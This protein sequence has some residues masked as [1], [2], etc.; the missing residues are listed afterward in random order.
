[1][2]AAT[3]KKRDACEKAIA[4]HLL[5][6][7]DIYRKYNPEGEY[8]SMALFSNGANNVHVHANNAYYEED[9]HAPIE[10]YVIN[11]EMGRVI[12]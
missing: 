2:K 4:K 8:L 9:K 10:F 5:A 12:P 11:G 1:M 3:E 6:I 7:A